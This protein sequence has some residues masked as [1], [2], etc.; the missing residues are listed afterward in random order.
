MGYIKGLEKFGFGE[1]IIIDY[2]NAVM[3]K[4]EIDQEGSFQD[5]DIRYTR[6]SHVQDADSFGLIE[7][8]SDGVG[9]Q[10]IEGQIHFF[11]IDQDVG[12]RW[13]HLDVVV[14]NLQCLQ[15]DILVP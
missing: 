10:L 5:W 7:N 1:N 3:G 4:I 14:R 6:S 8:I 9:C 15:T 2:L 12:I 11:D 13:D